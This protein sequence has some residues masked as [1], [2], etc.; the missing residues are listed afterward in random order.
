MK[1]SKEPTQTDFLFLIG[2]FAF[3]VLMANLACSSAP[4]QRGNPIPDNEHAVMA[5]LWCQ[6][7]A[8]ARA[9]YYQTFN[10]AKLTLDH[11][12]QKRQN[13]N[14]LA[15]IVDIDE[16]VLD[17]SPYQ[18]N[19][20]KANKQYPSGWQEWTD[21]GIARPIPGAKKFLEYCRSRGVE[22][23]YVSNRRESSRAGTLRNLVLA[24]FPYAENDHLYLRDQESSKE[25]R[26]DAI[27]KDY[28][29]ILLVGDNLNDFSNEFENRSVQER[30]SIVDSLR[31]EFGRRFIIL[32]NP[33]Y[34][35]WEGAIYHHNTDI[36]EKHKGQLR[37]AALKGY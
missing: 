2:K 24:G 26:R 32:P 15:I 22:I 12:L 5:V 27:D 8:E 1:K 19:L 17:N 4:T 25:R 37:K 33:M 9:Q 18:A 14:D 7:S 20:I 21:L 34:G 23:F 10:L 36:S 35:D 31:E 3:F 16:T 11:N 13:E 28:E 30:A 29:I 6:T